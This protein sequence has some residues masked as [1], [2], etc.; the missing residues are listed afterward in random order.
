MLVK[1]YYYYIYYYVLGSAFTGTWTQNNS[2]IKQRTHATLPA[3][4]AVVRIYVVAHTSYHV[5]VLSSIHVKSV[6]VMHP[7]VNPNP[8]ISLIAE[9]VV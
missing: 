1:F 5:H 8:Q 7:W 3:W 9:V 2:F 4:I 6:L